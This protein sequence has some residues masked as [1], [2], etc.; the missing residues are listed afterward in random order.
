MLASEGLNEPDV[1]IARLFRSMTVLDL[2]PF[3]PTKQIGSFHSD[4]QGTF[5][6]AYLGANAARQPLQF[7]YVER[8]LQTVGCGVLPFGRIYEHR[9]VFEAAQLI[10]FHPGLKAW[11]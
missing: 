2:Y 11:R 3:A 8:D 1:K 4:Q 10:Q 7:F 5:I 6:V 9:D